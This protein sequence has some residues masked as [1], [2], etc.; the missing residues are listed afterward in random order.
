MRGVT[1]NTY[2]DAR[3]PHAVIDYAE[4]IEPSVLLSV[5]PPTSTMLCA[6]DFDPT[7]QNPQMSS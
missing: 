4:C 1:C 6:L 2:V 7:G 3:T 5:A